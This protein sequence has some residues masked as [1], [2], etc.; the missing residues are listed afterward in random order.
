MKFSI[1]IVNYN[2][3]YFLNQC[4]KSVELACKN[5]ESEVF[6]VDNNSTDQ[7]ND[8][9]EKE[10]PDVK[11]IANKDNKG[12][13]FANNQA[14]KASTGEYVLLLNPDTIVNTDTFSK[15]ID[16]MD[17]TPDAGGLGVKMV[18]GQGDFLPESKRGFPTPTVAFYKMFGLTLIFPKSRT[19]GKYHLGYLGENEISQVDVLSGAFM[20]LRKTTLEKTG[21]LDESYF[22]YGEDVDL[23]YRIIKAGYKNYYFPDT[24]IIHYKGESTKRTNIN[25]II[26]FYKAMI[27]FAR[28]HFSKGNAKVFSLLLN[29]AIYV[30]AGI[31]L[32]VGIARKYVGQIFDAFS[33][34]V[35]STL[36][37]LLLDATSILESNPN[38]VISSFG[39]LY[40][41]G[42]I[43]LIIFALSITKCYTES[44]KPS[45]TLLTLASVLA[46]T[47]G[48]L[49]SQHSL[50]IEAA[51]SLVG[52]FGIAYFAINISRKFL[53]FLNFEEYVKVNESRR[54]A[55]IGEKSEATRVKGM[56]QSAKD[57]KNF[58]GFISP[59]K[60]ISDLKTEYIGKID[61][62]KEVIEIYDL[63]EIIFCS[64]DL[65]P[66]KII[67]QMNDLEGYDI[68][69]KIA[70]PNSSYII[71]SRTIISFNKQ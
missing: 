1:V 47:A 60:V 46:I 59:Q 17:K 53:N 21:L 52:F 57:F 33:I 48:G 6:V 7:S 38:P 20:L 27:I 65:N 36:A 45:K 25:Y 26:V 63:N 43:I 50:S 64:E 24:Q 42:T 4:L 13:S 23:S 66:Q 18:D 11:L 31:A 30:R 51:I 14:I 41:L 19:F 5:I 62:L 9:V 61:Q 39:T 69:Y 68:L 54:I 71:G 37:C 49:F 2:V 56:L 22:M 16:F 3:K 34:A 10:F 55:V 28:T 70:P 8:M 44:I 40:H 67:E 35:I 15:I 12:F 29:T 32:V 58:V